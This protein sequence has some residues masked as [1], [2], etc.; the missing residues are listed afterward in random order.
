MLNT[1][2]TLIKLLLLLLLIK[3]EKQTVM[4]NIELTNI[5]VSYVTL[6]TFS[7]ETVEMLDILAFI[8]Y[9]RVFA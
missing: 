4:I 3:N 9:C 5:D 6:G 7:K 1:C 8:V 2:D